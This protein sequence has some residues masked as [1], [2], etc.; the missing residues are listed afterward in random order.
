MIEKGRPSKKDDQ[1][2]ELGK[3]LTKENIVQEERHVS[4]GGGS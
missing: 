2:A 4:R 3:T 1:N